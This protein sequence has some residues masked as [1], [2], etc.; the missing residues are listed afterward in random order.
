MLIDDNLS[1]M[2][3]GPLDGMS[4]Q[5][6]HTGQEVNDFHIA[7]LR[8]KLVHVYRW[9]GAVWEYAGPRKKRCMAEQYAGDDSLNSVEP[10]CGNRGGSSPTD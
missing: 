4:L 9:K 6:E 8:S 2:I 7:D 1:P 10:K 3:G 5:R